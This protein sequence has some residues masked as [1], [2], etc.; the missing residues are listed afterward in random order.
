MPLSTMRTIVKE[1]GC[2]YDLFPEVYI[3]KF[4]KIEQ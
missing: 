1:K 4:I 2:I 3:W